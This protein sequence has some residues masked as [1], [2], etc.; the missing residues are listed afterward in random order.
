MNG[1]IKLLPKL[2]DNKNVDNSIHIK[3][4]N[5]ITMNKIKEQ[6]NKLPL[7]HSYFYFYNHGGIDYIKL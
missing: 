2:C 7:S 4:I 5:D 1:E 6:I 3:T